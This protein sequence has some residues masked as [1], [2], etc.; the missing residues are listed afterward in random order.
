MQKTL[1][2]A[3]LTRI[4]S[5]WESNFILM[6]I[7]KDILCTNYIA[8][9]LKSSIEKRVGR[10]LSRVGKSNKVLSPSPLSWILLSRDHP[11]PLSSLVLVPSLLV[12]VPS[13]LSHPRTALIGLQSPEWLLRCRL[14]LVALHVDQ[15]VSGLEQKS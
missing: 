4:V 15:I 5:L 14:L 12:L 2:A 6:M 9:V 11:T 7:L 3:S 1:A 10:T 13:L 8:L